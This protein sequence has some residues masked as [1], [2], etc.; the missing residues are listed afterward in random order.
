MIED[1]ITD[2]GMY[3][4]YSVNDLAKDI[5]TLFV[6]MSCKE[7]DEFLAQVGAFQEAFQEDSGYYP[8]IGKPGYPL[9]EELDADADADAE[10]E[11]TP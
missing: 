5:S 8:I 2:G 4:S 7:N 10:G 1:S 9:K 3:D 11:P 6:G